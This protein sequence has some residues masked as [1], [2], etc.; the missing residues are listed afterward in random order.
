ML[1][2]RRHMGDDGAALIVVLLIS[3]VLSALTL[4]LA[5]IT[6]GNLQSARAAQQ[7]GAAVNAADAGVAQALTYLRSTGVSALNKCA[8]NCGPTN[9]WGS[10]TTPMTVTQP[11]KAGQSY[12]VW[13]EPIAPYPANKPGVYRIHSSGIAGGPAARAVTADVTLDSYK[14]P[15]GIMAKSVMGGGNAAVHHES[16]YT[17]GCVYKRSKIK[18]EGMDIAYNQPAAVH[19]SQVIT[20]DQ[21]SGQFC[22]ST[23][24]PIHPTT[25]SPSTRY[26]NT[27]YPN[28]QDKNGG[29]LA[30]TSCQGAGGA[31]PQT[32][33]I[34][35]DA[36]LFN[37][38]RMQ[39]PALTQAQIDSLKSIAM[40]QGNYYTKSTGWTSPTIDNAVMFFDLAQTDPGGLVNL[41]NVVGYS[42]TP[43]LGSND[44]NCAPKSL[45]IVIEGGNARLNSNQNLYASVFLTSGDPYGHVTKAN[46]TA[47][48][49]GTIYANSLDLTGTVDLHMDEC[50]LNNVSPALFSTEVS[51][52]RELD[53]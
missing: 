1:R 25:G 52:Y 3:A 29:P 33:L 6:T 37:S 24:K 22:P 51:T 27:T 49:T 45:V 38:Y 36:D 34:A 7:A 41:N 16:I 26:C 14:I 30:G 50:F 48:F 5:V 44:A 28:D 17:T 2:M 11:G 31:Y 10:K 18:F 40:S 19:S 12:Q 42:R 35:S 13:I 43:G 20:D 53:R 9:K 8:P 4:T 46:G 32:S 39:Q 23:K 47:T 21:G 15:F